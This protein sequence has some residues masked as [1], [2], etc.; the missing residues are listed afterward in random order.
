LV[1][2]PLFF[3]SLENHVCLFRGVQV[4]GAA[5]CATMRIMAGVGDLVQRTADGCIG[6]VTLCVVYTVHLKMRSTSFLVE[7]QNE[8]LQFV[9]GLASKPLG[10]FVSDLASKPLGRFSPVWPQNR[11][12]QFFPVWPQTGGS[13]F[14][15]WASKPAATVW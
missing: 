13:G 5:W 10:R 11:W 15:V 9:S 3:V 6:R 8:G 14:L 2:L 12:Q 1:V 4:A 7:P